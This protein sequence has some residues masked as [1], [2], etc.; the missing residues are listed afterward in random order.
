MPS[1]SANAAN[2]VIIGAAGGLG[3][4]IAQEF[5][6]HGANLLL[7]GRNRAALDSVRQAVQPEAHL[8]AVDLTDSASLEALH[9]E[10]RRTYNRVDVV[11]NAA[12]ADVRKPFLKHSV[13]EIQRLA[14][15]NLLGAVLLT[16]VFL[17]VLLD[18]RDG[19]IVHLGGFADGRLAFPFYSVDVATRAAVRAFTES[20]NREIAGSGVSL[21][22][23]SPTTADTEAERPYHALWREMGVSIAPPQ[24]VAAAL[25][26]SIQRREQVHIMGAGARFLAGLNA[27][28]PGAADWLL[29]R[30]YRDILGRYLAG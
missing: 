28:W 22:Y 2:V 11:I 5:A 18:Q 14:D 13:D 6:R 25:Y 19:M 9:T 12:G 15:V 1:S 8:Y 17:P 30:R 23:F 7:V 24:A 21:L 16:R 27:V 3:T 4:A 26:Q 29:L 10:I 20:V